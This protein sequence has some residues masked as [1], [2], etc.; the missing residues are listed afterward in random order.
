MSLY[1]KSTSSVS[2]F[3]LGWWGALRS[4]SFREKL[5][6]G[7]LFILIASSIFYWGNLVYKH[8]TIAIPKEGG[9]YI[10]GTIGNPHRINP[11]FSKA[12]IPD[13]EISRLVYSGLLKYDAQG[14]LIEDIAKS[15]EVSEDGKTYTVQLREDVLWHDGVSLNAHDITFTIDTIKNAEYSSPFR[16][17]W[18]DVS[19][20]RGE[21]DYQA[22]FTLQSPRANFKENLTVGILPKHIWESIPPQNFALHPSNLEP[23]GTGPYR[24][25]QSQK[26]TEGKILIYELSSF[27]KYYGKKPNIS[28]VIFKFYPDRESLRQ[29]YK[30]KEVKG[31]SGIDTSDLQELGDHV[32]R[33]NLHAIE[34]PHFFVVYF[35]QSKSKSLAYKEVRNALNLATNRTKIVEDILSGKGKVVR[36]PFLE[37]SFTE[38]SFEDRQKKAKDLLEENGWKLGADGVREKNGVRIEFDMYTGD[39]IQDLSVTADALKSQWEVIGV[40]VNVKV[41]PDHDLF[42]NYMKPREYDSLLYAHMTTFIPDISPFWHS[43]KTKDPG[44][45]FS[46]YKNDELDGFLDTLLISQNDEERKKASEGTTR[47]FA[48]ESPALYLYSPS[49]IYPLDKS[50]QGVTLK[51]LTEDANRFYDIENWYIKTNRIWK[52]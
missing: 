2:R 52:K 16:N 45:N 15:W 5:V 41:L 8:F 1:R 20:K 27:A 44:L 30:N 49:Y 51:R 4:F 29:A 6:V 48:E 21:N 36:G 10:E 24:F 35:N 32:E 11:I 38:E 46:V 43:T 12:N 39:I 37:E 31:L 18:L 25:E 28:K 23:I 14:N 17:I 3:T 19:V 22:I 7:S 34:V 42:N 33:L 9:T 26:D 13:H 50:I 40:R 47:I